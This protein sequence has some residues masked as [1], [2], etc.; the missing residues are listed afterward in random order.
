MH[1]ES[2]QHVINLVVT[3]TNR[4]RAAASSALQV[5][6]LR[7]RSI[8]LRISSWSKKLSREQQGAMPAA[9]VYR[10]DHWSVVNS[11]ARLSSSTEIKIWIASAGYGLI[12]P[13]SHIVPYAATFSPR[14]EDS[15]ARS[16]SERR[17]WWA[18]ITETP[19]QSHP[20]TLRSL[21]AVARKHKTS[22][23]IIAASPEYID[24]MADDILAAQK[25]LGSSDLLSILCRRGAAPEELRASSIA[26]QAD[27]STSLGGTL[28]SLSARVLRWLVLQECEMLTTTAITKLLSGLALQSKARII[29]KRAR[30]TDTEVKGQIR[31]AFERSAEVSRTSALRAFRDSGLAVEQHRF[32]RIYNEV[33]AEAELG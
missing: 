29:P 22:P 21:R 8:D 10:G 24:A 15:V 14:H 30:L 27:F 3:C 6:N 17:A 31:L 4:K 28:T 5:R 7:G 12:S 2:I 11:I 25:Q 1:R 33:R 16:S 18:G 13:A 23:L 19:P 20:S 32:A 26:L 9:E